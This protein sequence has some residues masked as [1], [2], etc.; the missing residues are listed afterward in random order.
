[1]AQIAIMASHSEGSPNALLEAMAAGLPIVATRVGGIPEI[2]THEE[3]ALLVGARRPHAMAQAIQ[4]LLKD[5]GL[6]DRLSARAKATAASY[7]PEA[8]RRSLTAVYQRAWRDGKGG[9]L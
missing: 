7:S 2:A 3:T 1:M 4:R 6:R 5:R 8:Y 9:R